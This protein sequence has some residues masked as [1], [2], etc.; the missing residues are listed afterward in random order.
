MGDRDEER[1]KGWGRERRV[2]NISV[3]NLS[4]QVMKQESR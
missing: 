4:P 1:E 2:D 3:I